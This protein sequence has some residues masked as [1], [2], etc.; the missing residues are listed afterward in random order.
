M[1]CAGGLYILPYT[2]VNP[3]ATTDT[4]GTAPK[5]AAQIKWDGDRIFVETQRRQRLPERMRTNRERSEEDMLP[6]GSALE[7]ETQ[8]AG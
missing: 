8:E 6:T 7:I 2:A 4:T 1:S 3:T 5:P